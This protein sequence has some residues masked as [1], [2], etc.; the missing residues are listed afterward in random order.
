MSWGDSRENDLN[1]W[2][3]SVQDT[4]PGFH[5]GPGAPMAA[6][7]EEATTEARHVEE[8]AREGNGPQSGNEPE[9]STVAT[10]D[11][12]P[13]HQGHGERYRLI[14]RQAPLRVAG[15]DGGNGIQSWRKHGSPNT[16][17][18]LLRYF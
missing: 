7:L 6:A 18:A 5:A 12:R 2:M 11:A 9:L 4:G 1:R 16:V 17:P 10:S 8:A 14:D 3:L 15:C 13:S